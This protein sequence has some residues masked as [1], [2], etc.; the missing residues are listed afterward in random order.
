MSDSDR[1]NAIDLLLWERGNVQV[2]HHQTTCLLAN[3]LAQIQLH[4]GQRTRVIGKGTKQI[5]S[6]VFS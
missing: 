5:T 6:I 1:A 3:V 4:W 2:M